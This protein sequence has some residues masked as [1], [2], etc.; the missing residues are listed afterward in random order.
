MNTCYYIVIC[1]LGTYNYEQNLSE[2]A[3]KIEERTRKMDPRKASQAE[4][5]GMGFNSR[6]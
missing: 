4:R 2:Q 5:L 6:T 3:K 1:Y